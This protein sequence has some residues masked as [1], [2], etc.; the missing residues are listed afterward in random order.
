[1]A[2]MQNDAYRLDMVDPSSCLMIVKWSLIT[3]CMSEDSI[4]ERS[5]N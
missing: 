4:S 2:V 5:R 3:K 1:M